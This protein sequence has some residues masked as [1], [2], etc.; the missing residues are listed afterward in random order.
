MPYDNNEGL[1]YRLWVVAPHPD[2]EA[3]GAYMMLDRHRGDSIITFISSGRPGKKVNG[4]DRKKMFMSSEMLD[5]DSEHLD[6]KDSEFNLV[7]EHELVTELERLAKEHQPEV[8]LIP[9]FGDR[10]Q[11]HNIT[12][13]A[14]MAAIRPPKLPSVKRILGYY[15]NSSSDWPEGLPVSFNPNSFIPMSET[16]LDMKISHMEKC[17]NM[18]DKWLNINSVR[19]KTSARYFGQIMGCNIC[20]PYELIYGEI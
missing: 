11:D 15:T 8:V 18:S 5:A 3:L 16:D 7:K 4:D 2:D 1:T 10:N 20:E 9:S 6:L 12:S 17:Y 19:V 14:V 13:R